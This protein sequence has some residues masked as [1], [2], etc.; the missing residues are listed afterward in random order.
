[1]SATHSWRSTSTVSGTYESAAQIAGAQRDLCSGVIDFP[2]VGARTEEANRHILPDVVDLAGFGNEHQGRV[3]LAV[4]DE[5]VL[6]GFDA[7]AE[8]GVRRGAA[9]VLPVEAHADQPRRAGGL[10]AEHVDHGLALGR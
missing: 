5:N 6:A 9:H 8:I 1:M 4:R 7:P 2:Q 3:V 10:V